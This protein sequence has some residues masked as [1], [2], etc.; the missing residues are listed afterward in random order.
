MFVCYHLIINCNTRSQYF[1]LPTIETIVTPEDC[2]KSVQRVWHS[3]P[4]HDTNNVTSETR[5]LSCIKSMGPWT[6]ISRF[7]YMC[8]I[9]KNFSLSLGQKITIKR[10]I[11]HAENAR[12]PKLLW[13]NKKWRWN[14]KLI[15]SYRWCDGCWLVWRSFNKSI[16]RY[17]TT[18]EPSYSTI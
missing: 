12:K 14:K 16:R 1:I 2:V 18:N 9:S 8:Q 17:T 5:S 4:T 15:W 6:A 13:W 7:Y 3:R 11:Q 10:H